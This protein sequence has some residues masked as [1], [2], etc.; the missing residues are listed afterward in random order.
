MD[1]ANSLTSSLLKQPPPYKVQNPASHFPAPEIKSR[2]EARVHHNELRPSTSDTVVTS[3]P[4]FEQP[5]EQPHDLRK[6]SQQ[7][8]IP[9]GASLPTT[10]PPMQT[11]GHPPG[12]S[13]NTSETSERTAS[14]GEFGAST[15]NSEVALRAVSGNSVGK[16]DRRSRDFTPASSKKIDGEDE[17]RLASPRVR[18]TPF[19]EDADESP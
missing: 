10:I 14:I 5:S 15:N 9:S 1:L 6:V 18:L 4:P 2:K 7:M 19:I 11:T 3:A 12:K 13:R 8:Y 16:G 17:P